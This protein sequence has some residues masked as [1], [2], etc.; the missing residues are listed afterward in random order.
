MGQPELFS[1]AP[2]QS[3]PI[4]NLQL[5][6]L[7]SL[8]C[9]VYSV[10]ANTKLSSKPLLH[11]RFH[12]VC[13]FSLLHLFVYFMC[14]CASIHMTQRA[15]VGQR[16]TCGR[17]FSLST[18][19]F[20]RIELWS[21]G[22]SVS[23]FAHLANLAALVIYLFPLCMSVFLACLYMHPRLSYLEWMRIPSPVERSSGRVSSPHS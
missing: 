17:Q 7:S 9:F 10:L 15:W 14:M 5:Q 1:K 20:P 12:S 6:V 13:F 4:Q 2:S 21:P 3:T 11:I 18:L 19:C 8:L 23:T 16:T 22:L